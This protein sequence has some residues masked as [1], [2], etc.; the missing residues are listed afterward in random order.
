MAMVLV[1][2]D[3]GVVAETCDRIAVMYAGRIV[4]VG[5]TEQIITQPR[6]PYTRMLLNATPHLEGAAGAL[7]PI[8]GQPPDLSALPDGC[9]FRPRCPLAR[10]PCAD[11]DRKLLPLGGG[12]LA[13]CLYPD[14]VE[15]LSP[16]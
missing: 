3:I 8:P 1:S 11:F 14:R 12:R 6:H 16:P 7:R 2:H 4:E 10:D 15:E 13:A 5:S 9:L